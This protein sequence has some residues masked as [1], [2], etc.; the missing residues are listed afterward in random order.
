MPRP[1]FTAASSTMPEQKAGCHFRRYPPAA[2]VLTWDL[3]AGRT[4]AVSFGANGPSGEALL[5]RLALKPLLASLP[6][7]AQ[8][9]GAADD[10]WCTSLHGYIMARSLAAKIT[11]VWIGKA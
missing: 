10:S 2:Q 4:A 3:R 7:L 5:Q 1:G 11:V 8:Q 6:T 9:V